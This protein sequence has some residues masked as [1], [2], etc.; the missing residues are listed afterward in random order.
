MQESRSVVIKAIRLH[1]AARNKKQPWL[2]ARLGRSDFWLSRRMS[3]AVSFKVEEL[4][5]VAFVFGRTLPELIID[6]AKIPGTEH[7]ESVAS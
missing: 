7:A 5:E 3:G 2:S 4:E 6:A 1:L